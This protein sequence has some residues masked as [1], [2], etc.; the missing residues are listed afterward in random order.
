MKRLLLV[1]FLISISFF[2][3]AQEAMTIDS[4]GNVGIGKESEGEKLEVNGRIRDETGF[5]TPVGTVVAYIGL[6][7]PDGWVMCDGTPITDSKYADLRS[8][9]SA[10]GLSTA[11]TPDLRGIFVRGANTNAKMTKANN[12]DKYTGGAVGNEMTDRMQR[13]F[14]HFKTVVKR[15]SFSGAFTG[16]YAG[17]HKVYDADTNGYQYTFN[18]DSAGSKSTTYGNAR[19][20]NETAPASISLNYI[21]KY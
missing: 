11:K 9:L 12:I 21:I 15:N 2:L 19:T 13:I 10:S 1:I 3:F 16:V 7:P 18:F 17:D 6:T 20:S 14:G 4:S 8:V 5:V